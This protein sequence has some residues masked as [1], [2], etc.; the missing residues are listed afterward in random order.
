VAIA[1]N[2]ATDIAKE[3]ADI[4]LLNKDLEVVINGI[5][6]GRTI[7]VNINKYIVYTMVN[8]FGTFVA[9]AVLYVFSAN[10]PLLPIQILLTNILTDI[11][12]VT[13]YSDTV[14]TSDVISPEK[15][16]V[17]QL[18]FISLILGIPT[19][20]F[21]LCYFFIIHS[22]PLPVIQT[23]LYLYFTFIA[24]IVFYALR[25]KSYFWKAKRPSLLLNTSFIV[26]FLFSF[27]I[28][29][30][31]LF[32]HWFHFA[33]LSLPAVL[34]MLAVMVIYFITLDIIKVRYYS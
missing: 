7:F 33:S 9:L 21:E 23:S 1:V 30:I 25:N 16:N 8:N 32:Q 27:I 28:T 22:Q 14:E 29:Y 10:L 12:L 24:L 3:S 4:I 5:R 17:R 13:I 11:P 15:H 6:Y 19:A 31:P 26:A 2:S 20:L 18:L 34:T